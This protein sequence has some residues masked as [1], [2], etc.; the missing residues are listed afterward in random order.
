MFGLIRSRWKERLPGRER[1]KREGGTFSCVEA[2]RAGRSDARIHKLK[3]RIGTGAGNVAGIINPIALLKEADLFSHR[4]HRTSGIIAKDLGGFALAGAHLEVDGVESDG[5]DPDQDI[6]FRGRWSWNIDGQ[7]CSL[8]AAV[9]D[10]L[11]GSHRCWKSLAGCV[12]CSNKVSLSQ[13]ETFRELAL[14]LRPEGI[15]RKFASLA[16]WR[17]FESQMGS[18]LPGRDWSP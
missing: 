5:L 11:N 9:F 12:P 10:E 2:R 7:G 13:V 14:S 1:G 8:G 6:V 3:F 4:N 18:S 17:C 16:Q 15:K